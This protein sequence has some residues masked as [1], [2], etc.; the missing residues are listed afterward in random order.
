[1]EIALAHVWGGFLPELE[2]ER[3][4]L[5]RL[6]NIMRQQPLQIKVRLE[7]LDPEFETFN[8]LNF[9]IDENFNID[10]ICL[11]FLGAIKRDR[12]FEN[13]FLNE[14]CKKILSIFDS[15]IVE[16]QEDPDAQPTN[17]QIAYEPFIVDL[18]NFKVI[19]ENASQSYLV[20]NQGKPVIKL[21]LNR[22]YIMII[23]PRSNDYLL[24]HI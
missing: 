16:F 8:E 6:K 3:G 20:Q 19:W 15:V 22:R 24:K 23:K 14:T 11:A 7:G 12:S 17:E 10:N 21:N 13:D 2:I 1:L 4:T 5:P 9:N 18:R